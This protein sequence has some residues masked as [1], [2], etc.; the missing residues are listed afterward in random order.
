MTFYLTSQLFMLA[1]MMKALKIEFRK[2]NLILL[3]ISFNC[4]KI[5]LAEHEV[6]KIVNF[7]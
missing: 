5:F 2:I 1:K 6:S 7:M 4:V 3:T